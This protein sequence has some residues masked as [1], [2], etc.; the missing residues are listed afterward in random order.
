MNLG[1]IWKDY[2]SHWPTGVAPTGVLVTS[3][4]EQ[5]PFQNFMTGE[6][7][8]VVERRAPDT[9]GARKVLLPYENIVAVKLVDVVNDSVFA[10]LGFKPPAG[11]SK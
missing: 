3:Y 11:R 1:S 4:D 10:G 2:F 9:T 7:L 5:I 6:A 8:L